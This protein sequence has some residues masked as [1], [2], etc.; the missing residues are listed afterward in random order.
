MDDAKLAGVADAETAGVDGPK[1]TGVA[2]DMHMESDNEEDLTAEMDWK[3]GPRSHDHNLRPRKPCDYS[4]L[5]GDLEHTALTQYNV[6]KGLK[7]FGEAGAQA[8][9]T[10]MQQLHNHDVVVPKHA[11][12]LT[13]RRSG[14]LYNI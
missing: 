7:I 3:Y 8:V 9:I 2:A 1:T 11:S 5:H 12:I 10:E 4:H 14:V 6:K 13:W